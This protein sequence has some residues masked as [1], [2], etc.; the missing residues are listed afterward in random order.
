MPFTVPVP[1][2]TPSC[3]TLPKGATI[4][5]V[6]VPLQE[7]PPIRDAIE[8]ES[9]AEQTKR[10]GDS[11]RERERWGGRETERGRERMGRERKSDSE[12]ERRDMETHTKT[13]P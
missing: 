8:R 5:T 7:D 3:H 13:G 12:K 1:P 6:P 11:N 2:C 10:R 9:G 4:L